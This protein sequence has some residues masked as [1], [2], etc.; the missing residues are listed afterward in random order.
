[1][2][3]VGIPDGTTGKVAGME[4]TADGYSLIIEWSVQPTPR[5]SRFSKDLYQVYVT[6][7]V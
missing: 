5:R 2:A 1:M 6:E 3:L 4:E 7:E